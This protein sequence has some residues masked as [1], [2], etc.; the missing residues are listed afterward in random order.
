MDKPLFSKGKLCPYLSPGTAFHSL[1]PTCGASSP[2]S[3]QRVVVLL[4]CL[5]AVSTPV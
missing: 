2:W 1:D 4:K 5:G 3:L